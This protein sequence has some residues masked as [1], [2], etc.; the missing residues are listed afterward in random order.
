MYSVWLDMIEGVCAPMT[1][2]IRKKR[3]VQVMGKK[4]LKYVGKMELVRWNEVYKTIL[5]NLI[6]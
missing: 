5:K 1:V 3:S 6:S 2:Q 4:I